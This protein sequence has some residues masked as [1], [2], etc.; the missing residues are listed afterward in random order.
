MFSS[1]TPTVAQC[2]LTRSGFR[3]YFERP[4]CRIESELQVIKIFYTNF[5]LFPSQKKA[6]NE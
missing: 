1:S 4:F 5:V 3:V 2:S 6:L